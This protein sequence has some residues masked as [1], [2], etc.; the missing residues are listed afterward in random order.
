M[1][2]AAV[3]NNYTGTSIIT[4]MNAA[5]VVNN[6]TGT[7]IITGMNAAAVVNIYTGTFYNNWFSSAYN[8]Y[9]HNPHTHT[10]TRDTVVHVNLECIYSP[11]LPRGLTKLGPTITLL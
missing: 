5:A 8:I 6:Y 11:V 2:A 9:T 1:N 4:G 3:V 10:H 7:S